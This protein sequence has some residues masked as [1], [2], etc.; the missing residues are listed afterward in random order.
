VGTQSR[1]PSP[2]RVPNASKAGNADIM[3]VPKQTPDAIRRRIEIRDAIHDSKAKT[4]AR[5]RL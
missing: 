3:I 2:R 1:K 5:K 4:I